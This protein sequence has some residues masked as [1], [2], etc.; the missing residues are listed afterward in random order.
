MRVVEWQEFHK[1]YEH[2]G[3]PT[4]SV[5]Y[6]ILKSYEPWTQPIVNLKIDESNQDIN[7]QLEWT[8]KCLAIYPVKYHL[9][10][11]HRTATFWKDAKKAYIGGFMFTP[12][13]LRYIKS[14]TD[15]T[16]NAIIVTITTTNIECPMHTIE[17]NYD[18]REIVDELK[19]AFNAFKV[20][21]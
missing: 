8:M 21:K 15:K 18:D 1:K 6:S 11:V 4:T 14:R 19:A 17:F 20:L 7:T 12:E 2:L 9:P 16:L 10:E 5:G 13:Q 3:E